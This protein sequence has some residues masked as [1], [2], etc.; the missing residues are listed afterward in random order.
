MKQRRTSLK[1]LADKLGVSIATVSR[2]L[3]N[4][5][6]VGEEMT[7]KVKQLAKELNYRPNPFAQSL[8]KEAPRVIGVIVPNLVTHYYAAVLDGIEDYASKLGYSVISAN[9]H[10]NHER[11]AKALDNFLNMHVE[12][13]IACLAAI[14]LGFIPPSQLPTGDL[15]F[16]EGFL[17]IG[18][19]VLFSLPLIIWRFRKSSWKSDVSMD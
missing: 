17:G 2:A 4:S 10:E 14:V 11:E 13:I 9:S 1:D 15:F 3:R 8:R 19:V 7:Q 12:G 18:F 6:E 5:H 16:Y